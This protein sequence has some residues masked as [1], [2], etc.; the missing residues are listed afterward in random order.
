MLV[1]VIT[2]LAQV[3]N[4]QDQK[5]ILQKEKEEIEKSWNQMKLDFQECNTNLQKLKVTTGN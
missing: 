1:F 3:T 2:I 4:L 5:N